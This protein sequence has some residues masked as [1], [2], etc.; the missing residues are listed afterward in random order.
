MATHS[1]ELET[2]RDTHL[3]MLVSGHNAGL[4]KHQDGRRKLYFVNV[5][6]CPECVLES[7]PTV[8]N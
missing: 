1:I 8:K 7:V 3:V 4:H 2:D 6:E 5:A